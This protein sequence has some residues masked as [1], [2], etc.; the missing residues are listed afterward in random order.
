MDAWLYA[1]IFGLVVALTVYIW[2]LRR[3]L[4]LL[5]QEHQRAARN[6]EKER[7]ALEKARA[8]L[9]AVLE[10]M[11]DA[12]L[13]SDAQG[14]IIY[15]NRAASTLFGSE[16]RQ[17]VGRSVPE[18]LRH[19]QLVQTWQRSQA[20][21]QPCEAAVELPRQRRFVQIAALPEAH[22][23]GSLIV[24]QDLT[25]LRALEQVRRNFIANFSHELRTPLASL[26]A[27]A[28]TL[29]AGALD[30]P[31][32]ARRFLS[33]IVREVEALDRLTQDMLTLARLESGREIWQRA[34]LAPRDLLA[35][36]TERL[37]QQADR[38]GVVLELIA[39]RNL[40][41]LQG[42]RAALERALMNLVHN[43]IK[44]TPPGGLITLS[45]QAQ[46]NAVLFQVR[47]TGPGIDP[48]D[49]PHIFER[50]YK[51]DRGRS[52]AGAGLGLSI[53]RHIV[54]EH[55][56]RVWVESTPGEGSLFCIQLPLN[57]R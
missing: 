54:Q 52:S 19:H 48:E 1:P 51:V 3:R 40:P 42:D 21:G 32:D 29:T 55:G 5:Q 14:I 11:T 16:G 28:E 34:A 9:D 26:R 25:R 31:Q 56:G 13:M 57:D 23:K 41:L 36:V 15:A 4:Q 49:L 7:K 53:V 18:V 30:N 12:V 50:F 6:W 33:L 24:L 22:G 8:R 47:D 43:A 10:Q 35:A 44:F 38:N 37:Q 46:G 39:S 17:L 45:A 2:R 27:L 20:T